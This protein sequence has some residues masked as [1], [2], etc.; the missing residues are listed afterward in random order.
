MID[1][2]RVGEVV[3]RAH[4]YYGSAEPKF[5][6]DDRLHLSVRSFLSAQ[7]T[8][9]MT[10]LDIGCGK[11]DTLIE[12]S[13]RIG[14]GV[15]I[16]NDPEHVALARAA[17][18]DA[19]ARN[20]DVHDLTID[21]LPRQG[22]GDRFDLVFSERGPI[23]CE[24][25]SVQ[26][27]LSVLRTDGILFCELIGDLHHQEVREVF[28]SG[29]RRNQVMR[30]SDQVRVAMERNGMGVRIAADLIS[31]RIYPDIYEWLQF[32]CSIWAWSGVP[33]PAADD[34]RIRIFAERNTTESGE[35]E[36]TH[37]VVWIGGVKLGRHAGYR[38][39]QHFG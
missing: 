3:G 24:S 2:D 28:G 15:G 1:V 14:H 20:V 5:H 37:H 32:Q 12:L 10:V 39:F 31:K 26:S 30:I 35:I 23:G 13:S 21:D 36:T 27:G 22:W 38:E 7:V 17:V 8:P 19:G 18:L 25:W 16:E 29:V 34:P 4:S 6:N 9:T 33:L 11:A